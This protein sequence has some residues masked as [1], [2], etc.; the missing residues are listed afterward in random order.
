MVAC[1]N[2][3]YKTVNKFYNQLD[4]INRKIKLISTLNL[5][6][7]LSAI[8]ST[9]RTFNRQ[10]I[11]VRSRHIQGTEFIEFIQP[12]LNMGK[13]KVNLM[14]MTKGKIPE[15]TYKEETYQST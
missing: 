7:P 15:S 3:Q 11:Y 6:L 5:I 8:K 14:M 4:R 13:K 9:F 10:W 1:P 12:N 2:K